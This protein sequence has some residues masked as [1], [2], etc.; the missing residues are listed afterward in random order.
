MSSYLGYYES[1]A[2]ASAP[3]QERVSF[4]RRTYATLAIASL[5]FLVLEVILVKTGVAMELFRAMLGVQYGSL[6]VL[7]MLI[8][9]GTAARYFASRRRRG[10]RRRSA[11]RSTSSSRRS[12]SPR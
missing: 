5:A 12:S 10:P 9:G 11:W 1:Q 4:I 2:V 3:T 8:V 7:G 6:I